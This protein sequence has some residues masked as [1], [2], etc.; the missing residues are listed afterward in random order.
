MPASLSFSTRRPN[1]TST[2]DTVCSSVELSFQVSKNSSIIICFHWS[3]VRK[4]LPA[5]ITAI[6]F[7][8]SQWGLYN[9]LPSQF[10]KLSYTLVA[11]TPHEHFLVT[12]L[13][14]TS[15]LIDFS[16]SLFLLN[17]QRMHCL[18]TVILIFFF[19]TLSFSSSLLSRPFCRLWLIALL[20]EIS[21]IHLKN[22][23]N[24]YI[25]SYTFCNGLLNP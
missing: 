3:V 2:G 19:I 13:S 5:Y 15:H 20:M 8:M 24:Y 9:F 16:R 21:W 23:F 6:I 11:Q 22:I 4:T 25:Y 14:Y 18:F 10:V 17:N 12:S 1:C 7:W